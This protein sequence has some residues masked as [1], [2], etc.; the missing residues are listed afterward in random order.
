MEVYLDLVG[1]DVSEMTAPREPFYG[2]RVKI[3]TRPDR[4][5]GKVGS[6]LSF[7]GNK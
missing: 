5:M 2:R 4:I 6:K 1:F 3:Q 7:S